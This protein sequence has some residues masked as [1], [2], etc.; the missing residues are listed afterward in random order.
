MSPRPPRPEIAEQFPYRLSYGLVKA[1]WSEEASRWAQLTCFDVSRNSF[2]S[3]P[4]TGASIS[5]NSQPIYLFVR[6][7]RSGIFRLDADV[8]SSANTDPGIY[9][10]HVVSDAGYSEELSLRGEKISLAIP[11]P[12]GTTRILVSQTDQPSASQPEPSL[13]IIRWA[14]EAGTDR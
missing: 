14:V 13:R 4:K 8:V 7:A 5:L 6:I 11:V 3:L 12:E 1:Y 10:L 2:L 9:T